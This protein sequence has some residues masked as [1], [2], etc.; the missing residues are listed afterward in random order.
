MSILPYNIVDGE[1]VWSSTYRFKDGTPRPKC[2]NVG[3]TNAVT[4]SS[5]GEDSPAASRTLRTVCSKC[6]RSSY[7]N[8]PLPTGVTSHKKTYC[9]NVDGRIDGVIC[10]ATGLSSAQLELDHIDG[11]HINNIP[12][13]VQTLCKNCHSKKSILAGDYRK[14]CKSHRSP[15]AKITNLPEPP[16]ITSTFSHLFD[17]VL[18]TKTDPIQQT[19]TPCISAHAQSEIQDC[20]DKQPNALCD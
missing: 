19:P 2:I 20:L 6:H 13:N 15:S 18:Q 8:K 1:I 4:C 11:N 3:C 7:G 10:T 17:F 14:K 5:G 16:T 12:S 9:E